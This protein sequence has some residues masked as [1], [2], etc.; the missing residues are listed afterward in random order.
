VY[1]RGVFFN[2]AKF[3]DIEYQTYG[4]VKAVLPPNERSIYWEH[5]NSRHSIRITYRSDEGSGKAVTGFIVLGVRYRQTVCERWIASGASI[6]EVLTNL[7]AANFDPEFFPQFERH[8]VEAY[9]RQAGTQAAPL[10][11]QQ[12][13]GSWQSVVK[14][15]KSASTGG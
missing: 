3:F 2:S 4:T 9:N 1:K 7:G 5:P 6:E 8:L 13:R 14:R 10:V 15:L 11:L 12:R